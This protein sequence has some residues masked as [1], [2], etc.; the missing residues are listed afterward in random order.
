MARY[1]EKQRTSRIIA[2]ESLL[3]DKP[4]K[5]NPSLASVLAFRKAAYGDETMGE[6]ESS[7][8]RSIVK[9]VP[10]EKKRGS[11]VGM[12]KTDRARGADRRG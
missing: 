1:L 6:T 7:A 9:E 8:G 12:F 11:I 2:A 4:K 10:S 5:V 3:R